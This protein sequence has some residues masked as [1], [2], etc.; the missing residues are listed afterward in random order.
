MRV[1]GEAFQRFVAVDWSGARD[2]AIQRRSIC[3]CLVEAEG[4]ALRVVE[5]AGGLDRAATVAK[6]AALAA[7]PPPTLV[8]LDF[9]F[10]YAEPFLDH[11]G[12]PDFPALLG[13]M[14]RE[15]ERLEPFVDTTVGPWW[16]RWGD[17]RLRTRRVVEQQAAT[18]RAESP[19]RAL[20]AAGGAFGFTGPR[21]VGKAAITGLAAIA[22]LLEQAP[23]IGVWPFQE[24]AG[25]SMVLGEIWPRLAVGSV[26]KTDAAARA[27]HAA[28][29]R[30]RGIH[31]APEHE[32]AAIASDDAF[33]AL[34]SAVAMGLGGWFPVDRARLPRVAR[35]EGWILGVPWIA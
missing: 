2:P 12:V 22:S 5:L 33:D 27:R 17:D 35:R 16:Q 31:L 1:I 26:V 30:Q 23:R 14:R 4:R 13:R 6:L 3:C 34:V 24:L 8:G 25:R 19:L 29:L 10:S 18:R 7:D 15:A 9:P 21:Q 28:D 32:Q 20:P 11:L